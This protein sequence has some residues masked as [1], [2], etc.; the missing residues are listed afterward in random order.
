[1]AFFRAQVVPAVLGT[2]AVALAVA[3]VVLVAE[4]GRVVMES[5]MNMRAK[6]NAFFDML[7]AKDQSKGVSQRPM[8]Q[9]RYTGLQERSEADKYFASL[10][11]RP[12]SDDPRVLR[13]KK[14]MI[15][16]P[17]AHHVVHPR[18][19]K[20]APHPVAKRP[21]F[22]MAFAEAHEQLLREKAK[23][24]VLSEADHVKVETQKFALEKMAANSQAHKY[25]KHLQDL[26]NKVFPSSMAD[27]NQG[28]RSVSH[29][30]T[31]DMTVKFDHGVK[32]AKGPKLFKKGFHGK[33][34]T[35]HKKEYQHS[36]HPIHKSHWSQPAYPHHKPPSRITHVEDPMGHLVAPEMKIGDKGQVD[37][38]AL[39]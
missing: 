34:K 20:H 16:H 37:P 21:S 8:L 12:V 35:F 22:S 9:R 29:A 13:P 31:D 28:T 33:F 38:Q 14:H 7:A 11:N 26:S 10:A 24:R 1:M 6:E 17:V 30:L 19:I 39:Y 4:Q 3:C 23:M 27:D 18:Q 15:H 5:G 36:H 25:I 2:V 32:H